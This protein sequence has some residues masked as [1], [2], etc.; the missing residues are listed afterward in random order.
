MTTLQ[1]ILAS[2]GGAFDREKEEAEDR[3]KN[4]MEGE[5]NEDDPI[6]VEAS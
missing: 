3:Y 4:L 2:K 1:Y 5:I 6:P